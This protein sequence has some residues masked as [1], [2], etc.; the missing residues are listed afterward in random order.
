MDLGMTEVE[1][2]IEGKCDV[3]RYWALHHKEDQVELFRGTTIA[4]ILPA[5]LY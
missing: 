2:Q 1:R 4:N 5:K 3:E